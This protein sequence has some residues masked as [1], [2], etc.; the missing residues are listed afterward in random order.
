MALLQ[1]GGALIAQLLPARAP[2]AAPR[3]AGLTTRESEVAAAVACGLT[4]R[5]AC[6]E[7]G[8][9]MGTLRTHL[10][11][12]FAKLQVRSRTGVATLLASEGRH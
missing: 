8:I 12:V 4:D 10:S 11:R 9:S 3:I 1:A 6:R 2:V 7:L 5:Q